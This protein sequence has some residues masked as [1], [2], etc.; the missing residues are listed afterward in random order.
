MAGGASQALCPA[1]LH[2]PR[3]VVCSRWA[4]AAAMLLSFVVFVVCTHYRNGP[5]AIQAVVTPPGL[6][7]SPWTAQPPV[8]ARGWASGVQTA[9]HMH[10]ATAPTSDGPVPS[11]PNQAQPFQTLTERARALLEQG[12]GLVLDASAVA[13]DVRLKTDLSEFTGQDAYLQAAAIWA[14]RGRDEY[15]D[16][17]YEVTR[18]GETAPN[19][20]VAQWTV[21]WTPSQLK[22][23]V[24]L[25]EAWPGVVVK[26][27]DLLDR[28][29]KRSQFT[30]A[31]VAKLFWT[32]ATTGEMRLPIAAMPG[33]S[34]L[35]FDSEGRLIRQTESLQLLKAI[36]EERVQNK[37]VAKDVEAFMTEARRPPGTLYDEWDVVLRRDVGISRV[38]GMGQLDVEGM[39]AAEQNQFIE[40]VSLILNFGVVIVLAFGITTGYMYIQSVNEKAEM[41][42]RLL[43]SGYGY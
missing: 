11:T 12:R 24:A 40:N 18:I 29:D 35:E 41:M 17:R 8:T 5:W 9:H 2:M 28:L 19:T 36:R 15:T 4:M 14:R 22:G 42:Q 6:R 30:W 7:T 38:P 33:T 1:V 25:V 26:W 39:S 27:F 10:R 13:P 16:L 20:V 3:T 23:L 37:R 21:Y 43:D 34:T 32:A 31:A